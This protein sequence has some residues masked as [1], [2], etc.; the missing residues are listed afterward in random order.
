MNE[1]R[2][3]LHRSH[4]SEHEVERA[5][6]ESR[7]DRLGNARLVMALGA[8]ALLL[9]PLIARRSEPWWA[10]IPVGIAFLVLGRAQDAIEKRAAHAR[11]SRDYHDRELSRIDERWRGLP[12]E[13]SDLIPRARG[14]MD[15]VALRA[16]DL[17]LLGRS[18]LFQR[19][20]RSRTP[21]GRRILGS[22]LLG[23]ADG[24]PSKEELLLRQGAVSELHERIDLRESLSV[25]AE[26]QSPTPL[27]DRRIL[28]WATS[29]SPLPAPRLLANLGVMV[30]IATTGALVLAA[31]SL[32]PGAGLLAAFMAHGVVLLATRGIASS[33]IDALASPERSL[34]RY[35]DLVRTLESSRLLSPRGRAL[36]ER[37][38]VEG[39]PA[40]GQIE[41]LGRLVEKLDYRLNLFF[42]L[43]LGPLLLWDLNLALR[44]ETWRRSA[45]ARLPEWL[46]AVGELE[47]LASLAAELDSGPSVSFPE[48]A[49]E[50]GVFDAEVL[51]HPLIDRR[52][53]VPND[54]S[55]NGSGS[56]LLLSGSNMSG[57]STLLRS[58]GLA[59]AMA[60]SGGP[61]PA[62][63]LRV[64]RS[65]V[66]SSVRVVDSLERGASHFY[67]E[68]ERLKLTLD[69]GKAHGA[70]LVYLL[71]EVLHGTNSR[72]RFI[73][74][75]AAITRLSEAGSMGVVTTHDL[76]LTRVAEILP[77]G[78]V[79]NR[80]FGDEVAGRELSFDYKLKQGAVRSS[81]ALSLMRAIGIDVDLSSAERL[82]SGPDG[83]T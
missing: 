32:I 19:V 67:A 3:K 75:V 39:S 82:L 59:H 17:D 81:N 76:S 1:E 6:L 69:L 29:M 57:K 66:A 18:S 47:A 77:A 51:F 65:I 63:K 41:A 54:L 9:A 21:A 72:E 43:S 42:A 71:D 37:L 16:A 34:P 35:S 40:S 62:K 20:S 8:L 38:S 50:A 27:D 10:L 14:P 79:V 7:L 13:G 73:G 4:F 2:E 56:L 22:W 53:V 23:S 78:R 24:P 60:Y 83:E 12:D 70:K 49:D 58:I 80:H 55:L 30:P 61:V 31:L 15:L 48:I 74:A 28:E 36:R 25:A 45:G 11:A 68:L 33:R 46:E 52:S 26:T 64:S 44:A 5:A